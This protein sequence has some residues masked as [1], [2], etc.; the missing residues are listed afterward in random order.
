MIEVQ[1]LYATS[2]N[3]MSLLEA[4]ESSGACLVYRSNLFVT[5]FD[6]RNGVIEATSWF[7]DTRV[8]GDTR[9]ATLQ[10]ILGTHRADC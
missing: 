8:F 3:E 1:A 7:V 2:A 5:P 10:A 6:I 4:A 9:I